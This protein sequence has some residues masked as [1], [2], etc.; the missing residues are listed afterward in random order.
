MIHFYTDLLG[1]IRVDAKD[2][3]LGGAVRLVDP[4][5]DGGFARAARAAAAVE[6]VGRGSCV[7]KEKEAEK[8]PSGQEEEDVDA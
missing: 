1:S 5:L 3:V 4:V 8:R 6:P 7:A 2:E